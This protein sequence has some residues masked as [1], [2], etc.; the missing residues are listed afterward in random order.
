M[1]IIM[2]RGSDWT[3]HL[4][5]LF[6]FPITDLQTD[7]T[8]CESIL[9]L[10]ISHIF[11]TILFDENCNFALSI[12]LLLCYI[13]ISN[14]WTNHNTQSFNRIWSISPSYIVCV[15]VC[16]YAAWMHFVQYYYKNALVF[17]TIFGRLS[18][19]V[20]QPSN[21]IHQ[22]TFDHCIFMKWISRIVFDER[23]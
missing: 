8:F 16:V 20:S 3:L 11:G 21:S 1:K 12:S 10:P 22:R 4:H 5:A 13:T 18:S 15:C 17:C 2:Y 6:H 9:W 7:W 23:S 14:E 19:A